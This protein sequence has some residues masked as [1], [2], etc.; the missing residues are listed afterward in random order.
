MEMLQKSGKERPVIKKS[1]MNIASRNK[2]F[3]H[4]AAVES[5]K[6]SIKNAIIENKKPH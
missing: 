3:T 2:F 1:E 6:T 5:K 4:L